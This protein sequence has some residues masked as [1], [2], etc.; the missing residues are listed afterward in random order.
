[1]P[2]MAN[3]TYKWIKENIFFTQTFYIINELL[4]VFLTSGGTTIL[5][6]VFITSTYCWNRRERESVSQKL[7]SC[8]FVDSCGRRW[9]RE[10]HTDQSR[11]RWMTVITWMNGAVGCWWGGGWSPASSALCACIA[12]VLFTDNVSIHVSW[13]RLHHRHPCP[14]EVA[15]AQ[16]LTLS[17]N[18]TLNLIPYVLQQ[19]TCW[20]IE[21]VAYR[22][23]LKGSTGFINPPKYLDTNV[24]RIFVKYF[25]V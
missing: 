10:L 22:M 14:N 17:S 16:R 7:L 8:L 2:K 25:L 23:Q 13:L 5:H 24:T 15:P 6:A 11:V 18:R 1:M 20:L 19:A 3:S 21:P 9:L 4:N 12:D